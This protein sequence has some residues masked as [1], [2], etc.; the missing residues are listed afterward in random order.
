MRRCDQRDADQTV[1]DQ[2]ANGRQVL[3]KVLFNQLSHR[4]P[5]AMFI[6]GAFGLEQVAEGRFVPVSVVKQGT[7]FVGI[8]T[9][10]HVNV[11]NGGRG[12]GHNG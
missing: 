10:E 12:F 4:R 5:H 9:V 11:G 7:C 6:A 2:Q 8:A 3:K 1:V